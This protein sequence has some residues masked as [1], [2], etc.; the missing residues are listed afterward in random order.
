MGERSS[1]MQQH[2]FTYFFALKIHPTDEVKS[3]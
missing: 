2:V 1:I 3:E